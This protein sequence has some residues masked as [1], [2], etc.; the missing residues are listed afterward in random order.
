MIVRD[1]L[2]SVRTD[3]VTMRD[4]RVQIVMLLGLMVIVLLASG[5]RRISTG[6]WEPGDGDPVLV[7][8]TDFSTD[9]PIEA[10]MRLEKSGTFA[11]H[12]RLDHRDDSPG[13]R[14]DVERYQV[15]GYFRV[16]DGRVVLLGKRFERT[17]SG[18]EVGAEL[19]RFDSDEIGV[20]VP[21]MVEWKIDH[22]TRLVALVSEATLRVRMV[23]G[24]RLFD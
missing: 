16:L 23:P 18:Y 15:N 17:F 14:S 3:V 6:Y 19:F 22:D 12:I 2:A 13:Q 10:T 4:V 11:A 8:S 9:G 1:S 20:G 21:R 7:S 24:F 5:C